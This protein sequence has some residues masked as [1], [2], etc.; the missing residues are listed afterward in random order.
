MLVDF[1]VGDI[2]VVGELVGSPEGWLDGDVGSEDGWPDGV[3]VGMLVGDE[4]GPKD[5]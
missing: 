2:D 3:A 4:D 5:G 1:M